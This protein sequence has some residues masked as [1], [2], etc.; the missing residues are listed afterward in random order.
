[1]A[2]VCD[3][4]PLGIFSEIK[5]FVER[6]TTTPPSQPTM[7]VGPLQPLHRLTMVAAAIGRN[8]YVAFSNIRLT[9]KEVGICSDWSSTQLSAQCQSM[10]CRLIHNKGGGN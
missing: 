8:I 2:L 6:L 9:P 5:L 3:L 4:Y 10:N 7:K 1:M